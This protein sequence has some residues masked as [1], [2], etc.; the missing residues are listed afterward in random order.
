MHASPSSAQYFCFQNRTHQPRGRRRQLNASR[1]SSWHT[2][3]H[4]H[5]P[6]RRVSSAS[7]FWAA[8]FFSVIMWPLFR[9][10][11]RI[12]MQRCSKRLYVDKGYF[13]VHTIGAWF[14]LLL[15]LSMRISVM[16]MTTMCV[17]AELSAICSLLMGSKDSLARW[18]LVWP[19][20]GKHENQPVFFSF[21]Q[22]SKPGRAV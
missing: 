12:I 11:M 16:L 15:F 5:G 1:V 3:L 18:F 2:P 8:L 19:V 14:H 21:L 10:F 13:R 22:L 4:G 20:S 9:A 6:C 7:F 17:W